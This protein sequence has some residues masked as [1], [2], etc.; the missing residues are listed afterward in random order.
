MGRREAE[1]Q[2]SPNCDRYRPLTDT[3]PQEGASAQV[4]SPIAGTRQEREIGGAGDE[5][6][7]LL[8]AEERVTVEKRVVDR[9]HVRVRLVTDET[10]ELARVSLRSERLEIERVPV[11][12]EVEQA[13][14]M[15]E[16]GGVTIIPILE[17]VV[18][19]QKR[20][21]LKE[22]LHIRRIAE[23]REITEPVNVRRQRAEVERRPAAN[24]DPNA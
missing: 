23:Q 11:G 6:G 19:V 21:V 12:R 17:E 15:R 1:F 7:V 2:A 18:V 16:E 9:E 13:P 4:N 20:L 3:P 24:S 5:N 14:P 10:T 8:V 22:E